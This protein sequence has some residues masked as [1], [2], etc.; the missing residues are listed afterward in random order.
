M[1]A[2][3]AAIKENLVELKKMLKEHPESVNEPSLYFNK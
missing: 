1:N 3:Q 2:H